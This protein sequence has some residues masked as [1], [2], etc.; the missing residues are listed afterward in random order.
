MRKALVARRKPIW[1]RKKFSPVKIA[2][3]KRKLRKKNINTV[4][5]SAHCPN[6]TECFG[7]KT[8][9]FMILGDVCNRSCGFCAVKNGKPLPPDTREPENVARMVKEL[10]I[11]HAVITSVT[12]DDLPD[13]GANQ[14]ALTARALRE[15]CHGVKLEFLI[16]DFCGDMVALET[17]LSERP[18]ILNHNVETVPSLYR[19]VRPLAGFERSLEIL[20]TAASYNITTKSG[21]MCGLGESETELL[22][23]FGR[24]KEKR[25]KILT[26]GQYLAPSRRHLPVVSFL[27]PA[28]FGR[29]AGCARDAGIP[30][31]FAGP[32]V[33]SSYMAEKI[34]V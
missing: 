23:L 5:E 31:V 25:V 9:T 34:S 1:L 15:I 14:W 13:G 7:R 18:D 33:R 27:E 11:K 3:L 30:T 17:V 16:P 21:I 20:E 2:D 19:A 8:A 6:I 28:W 29:M 22:E 26:L 32:F 12:R 4:C 10:G 24:L